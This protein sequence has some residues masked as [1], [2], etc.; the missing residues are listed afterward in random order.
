MLAEVKLDGQL[1]SKELKP[2]QP[3]RT[4]EGPPLPA[5]KVKQVL[6]RGYF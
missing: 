4:I 5:D 2:S 3:G 6:E 1:E